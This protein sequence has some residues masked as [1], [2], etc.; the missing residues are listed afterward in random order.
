ME[1]ALRSGWFELRAGR[2]E[3]PSGVCPIVAAAKVAGIWRDG[4][5]AAGGPDWGD[6]DAPSEPM[7]TFAVCFDLHA[8]DVGLVAA[9]QTLRE[10]LRADQSGEVAA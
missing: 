1:L 5:C 3:S 10:A 9:I 2:W 7:M 6:E 4:H 8:E